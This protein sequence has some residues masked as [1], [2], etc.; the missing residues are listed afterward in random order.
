MCLS[1]VLQFWCRMW[2]LMYIDLSGIMKVDTAGFLKLISP[3]ANTSKTLFRP[4]KPTNQSVRMAYKGQSSSGIIAI[5]YNSQ[6]CK[7]LFRPIK[8]T[9]PSLRMAY[10]GQ[11]SSGIILI[12]YTIGPAKP[13]SGLLNPPIHQS[14]WPTKARAV[15][16]SLMQLS[17]SEVLSRRSW[18]VVCVYVAWWGY[19]MGC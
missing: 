17:F 1:W 18:K 12:L 3:K 10:K 15:S 6:A 14:G 4:N 13:Y 11:S 16:E 5:L 7:T 2:L 9:N 19:Q 8:P